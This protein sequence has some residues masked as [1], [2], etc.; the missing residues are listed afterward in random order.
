MSAS[1]RLGVAGERAPSR[2]ARAGAIALIATS[3][4]ACARPTSSYV[5]TSASQSRSGEYPGA[6]ARARAARDRAL[7]PRAPSAYD[8]DGATDEAIATALTTWAA[9]RRD[10]AQ[11]AQRAYDEALDAAAE[12]KDAAVV[13]AELADLWIGVLEDTRRVL[14][15]AAPARYRSDPAFTGAV[16]SAASYAL[17]GL[18]DRIEIHLL[19]CARTAGDARASEGACAK[20]AARFADATDPTRP[21]GRGETAAAVASAPRPMIPTT[22]PSPC[23]FRG[24]LRARG[25]VY[26]SETG[27]AVLLPVSVDTPIEVESLQTPSRPGGRYKV[28]VRWPSATTG[29]L[30]TAVPPLAIARHLDPADA[31]W[32]ALGTRVDVSDARG[33]TVRAAASASAERRLFC[34]D[35]E[36]ATTP[37]LAR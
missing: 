30:E 37:P 8:L 19:E 16:G 6:L 11:G 22:R 25:A 5:L 26:D 34:H 23:T 33:P 35:L 20:V 9:A 27:G 29:Y 13:H 18:V 2:L 32:A 12:P 17:R 36:L 10:A 15:A 28:T 7:D 24:T 31:T 1:P 4:G 21:D 3:I 14:F